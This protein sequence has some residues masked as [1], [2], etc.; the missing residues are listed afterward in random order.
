[1]LA[2]IHE[3]AETE[4]VS[5]RD[6][7]EILYHQNL[8]LARSVQ[9]GW[10]R[11]IALELRVKLLKERLE[12]LPRLELNLAKTREDIRQ[13]KLTALEAFHHTR[14]EL[15]AAFKLTQSLTTAIHTTTPANNQVHVQ[16]LHSNDKFHPNHESQAARPKQRSQS[17]ETWRYSYQECTQWYE[18]AWKTD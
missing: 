16:N 5:V 10:D 6:D 14:V 12:K 1:M 9:E 18:R 7:S 17:L 2:Q 4:P 8:R 15:R 13:L 3:T 11:N